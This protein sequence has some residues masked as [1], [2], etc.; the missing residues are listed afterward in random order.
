MNRKSL[1]LRIENLRNELDAL[2]DDD[3]RDYLK[4]RLIQAGLI[5]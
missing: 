2:T 1:R 4:A 5:K 3:R